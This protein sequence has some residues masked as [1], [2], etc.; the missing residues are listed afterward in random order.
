MEDYSNATCL[1]LRLDKGFFKLPADIFV[2]IV[3]CPPKSSQFLK[4]HKVIRHFSLKLTPTTKIHKN[5]RRPIF[6][7]ILSLFFKELRQD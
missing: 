4:S 1:V 5:Y 2:V 6:G 3:Y 7:V